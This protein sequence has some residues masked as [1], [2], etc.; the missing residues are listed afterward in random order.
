MQI[1]EVKWWVLR[2]GGWGLGGI[3][4]EMVGSVLWGW[5]RGEEME[6]EMETEREGKGKGVGGN[7]GKRLEIEVE[8]EVEV[9]VQ[10]E[11]EVEVGRGTV[12]LN[13]VL[14]PEPSP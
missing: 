6:E 11:V 5:T 4:E 12:W 3:T 7:G 9:E 1:E 2:E 8:V 13:G 14:T 10:V